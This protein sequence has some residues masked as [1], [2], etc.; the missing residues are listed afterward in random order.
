MFCYQ[1]CLFG[2]NDFFVLFYTIW[3][4]NDISQSHIYLDVELII[5]R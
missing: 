5:L 1:L 2:L 3:I 4:E